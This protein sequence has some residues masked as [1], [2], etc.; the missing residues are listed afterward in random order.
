MRWF[1]RASVAAVAVAAL[2]TGPA[3]AIAIMIRS[4]AQRAVTADVI[5][6]G[7]VT[8]IEKDTVE[9]VPFP[10][11]PNK[12]TYKVAVVKVETPLSGAANLTHVKVGFIPPPPMEPNAPVPPAGRPIRRGP[13]LPDLKEGQEFL[14]FLVKHPEGGGFYVMPSMSPPVETKGD[15]AKKEV[16]GVKKVTTVLADPAKALKA[17]KAEDRYFAA[18][19][20]VAK[21]RTYPEFVRGEVDQVPIPADESKQLLAALTE[22]DWSQ[23]DR[24]GP[25]GMQAFSSLGLTDKDGWK[26]PMIPANAD[27]NKVMQAAFAKWLDGPGKDYQIKKIVPKK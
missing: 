10:G 20:M 19:V 13:A 27:A 1:L 4:P 8:A 23:F 21:Y 7:K 2:T 14:F 25:N 3:A 24:T 18:T 9:A 26:F 11:S 22:G 17:E 12:V 16:E 15:E 5:V 6:V